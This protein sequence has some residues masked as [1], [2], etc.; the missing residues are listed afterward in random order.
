MRAEVKP[1]LFF[2]FFSFQ[3][4][5]KFNVF[6]NYIYLTGLFLEFRCQIQHYPFFFSL[7]FSREWKTVG[8]ETTT[9]QRW[10]LESASMAG[11]LLPYH[12]SL[13]LSSQNSHRITATSSFLFKID[14]PGSLV[15][16]SAKKKAGFVDQIL[17]YI[18]GKWS[19]IMEDMF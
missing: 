14:R 17:D 5:L 12:T 6:I 2:Y 16:C 8:W 10:A 19:V 15:C 1:G 4:F 7:F 3:Q 18:E 9:E 13:F 11:Y